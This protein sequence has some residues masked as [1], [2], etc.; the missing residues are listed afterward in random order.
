MK[1]LRIS[2]IWCPACLIMRPIYEQ[3]AN[4]YN[5]ETKELDFDFDESEVEPLNVGNTLPVTIIYDDNNNELA[6][7]CGEKK[8]EQ[9][10]ERIKELL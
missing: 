2:A 3:I 6:R 4:K 5:L 9:I 1:L 7:I 8:L 10:E